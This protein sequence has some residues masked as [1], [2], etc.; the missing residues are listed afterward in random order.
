MK[1]SISRT[2][3]RAHLPAEVPRVDRLRGRTHDD[4][5]DALSWLAWYKEGVF[6]AVL[7][8]MDHCDGEP[9]P[10]REPAFR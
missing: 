6:T 5:F 4:L 8:Y 10:G 3:A 9:I 1:T 2:T 7:D